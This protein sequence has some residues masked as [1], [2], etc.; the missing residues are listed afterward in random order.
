MKNRTIEA[1]NCEGHSWDVLHLVALSKSQRALNMSETAVGAHSLQSPLEAE[2]D[3]MTRGSH[4]PMLQVGIILI[5]N[6]SEMKR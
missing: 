5:G 4:K 6:L 1:H 3:R 2:L